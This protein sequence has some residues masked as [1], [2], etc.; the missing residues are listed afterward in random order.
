MRTQKRTDFAAV[1]R[2]SV[3]QDFRQ[4]RAAER[5]PDVPTVGNVRKIIFVNPN[6]CYFPWKSLLLGRLVRLIAPA[7][8]VGGWWCA[9]MQEDDRQAL[10]DAANWS[11]RKTTYLFDGV[12]FK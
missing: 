12:K 8:T 6:S 9:F 1:S 3:L 10:N 2:R 5:R 11:D 7:E 4:Q